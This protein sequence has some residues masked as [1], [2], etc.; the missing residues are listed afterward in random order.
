[1]LL[2][3][4]TYVTKPG[5]LNPHLALYEQYGKAPQSRILGQP[6]AFLKTE[7]G[8][9]NEFVHIW[10]FENAGDRETKRA[11]LW[12]DAEWL[13]YVKRSG[14]LGAL[15]SQENRLMTPVEFYDC[16]PSS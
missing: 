2:D 11:A 8:N 7:T 12:K 16:P 13:E 14:E 6:L 10:M 4:R 5:K 1:M 9:I 3:V 15:E